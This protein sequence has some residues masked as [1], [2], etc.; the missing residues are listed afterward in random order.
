MINEGK[1]PIQY[2]CLFHNFTSPSFA[3]MGSEWTR[4]S[5]Q[6]F[7]SSYQEHFKIQITVSIIV[8]L[9]WRW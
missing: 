6:T 8:L 7:L 3:L 4:Q 1:D 9:V 2:P 5:E